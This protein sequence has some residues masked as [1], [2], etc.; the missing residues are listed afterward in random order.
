MGSPGERDPR[1]YFAAE[2]TFL[3]W[4]R[5]GMALMGFGFVLAR[6]GLFLKEFAGLRSG[7]T[8]SS[9]GLSITIGTVLIFGGVAINA[10]S[11]V[12]Y[13]RL[14][15]ELRRGEYQAGRLSR[16]AIAVA[17]MLAVAGLAMGVWLLLM[18]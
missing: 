15:R 6:F 7:Q 12:G 5:T 16:T 3:A 11:A 18:R 10:S 8:F 1:V 17:V 14:I 13:I 4:I 9:T 2:R